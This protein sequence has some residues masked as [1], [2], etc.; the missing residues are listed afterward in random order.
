MA[1][2]YIHIPFCK[3]R[4]IYCAFYSTT[5]SGLQDDYVD[6]LCREMDTHPFFGGGCR[7]IYIGGGTPSQLSPTLLRRLLLYIY[8]VYRVA[9]DAEVTIEC[10]PDDITPEYAKAIGRLPINRVSLGAQTFNDERLRWLHRR[11]N[12]QQVA[13]AIRLLREVGI[14]NISIDLM[15]GFPGET[16]ADWEKDIRQAIALDV[17]HISAYSL[18][19]EEGTVLY[20]LLSRK[21]E[22][23]ERKEERGKRK[24]ERGKRKEERGERR[25]NSSSGDDD[26]HF[27]PTDEDD[28]HS[29]L[30]YETLIDRLTQAGYEHYE[31]SNFARRTTADH[32]SPYRSH[33]NSSYWDATPYLGIGAAAHSYDGE[34]RWW[35]KSDLKQYIADI[36]SDKSPIEET[37]TLDLETKYNDLITTALRTADGIQLERM[38]SAFG[39]A[40]TD[41]LMANAAPHIQRGM[42]AITDGR[43]H[44]TRRGL[45]V[46]DDIMS[47]LIHIET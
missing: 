17:E 10:N 6:A 43:L 38:L 37:E 15:F 45:F 39:K 41:Y 9:D 28:E 26:S 47:D 2:L 11:H 7:S 33:H 19:V 30:M 46:S 13:E 1:G 27:T 22:R 29:R 8:K 36:Q 21:E 31:I 5:L 16:L 42:L 40:Y 4:C 14:R 32:P 24:E 35:N 25:E 3:S 18:M 34:H 23:G 12:A 20:D 44:L